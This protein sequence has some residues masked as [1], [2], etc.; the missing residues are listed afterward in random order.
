LTIQNIINNTKKAMQAN[1]P[2]IFTGLGI[3]GVVSTA[4]LTGRASYKAALLI[5]WN[6]GNAGTHA[7]RKQRYKERG[8]L[9]W[10]LYIPPVACGVATI[11]C[12]FG[13]SR[14]TSRRA[15]AAAAA[16]AIAERGFEEYR[17]KV[18]EQLGKGK[19]QKIRDSIAQDKVEKNSGNVIYVGRGL[20][21]CCEL[22]TGRYFRSDMEALKKAEREIN[23]LLLSDLYVMMSEFYDLI[24]LPHTSMSDYM[25]WD[26]GRGLELF[27][28]TTLS[29]DGEPCVAFDYNY[30]KPLA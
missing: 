12:I 10:K 23:Q 15:T 14:V 27:F 13:L 26:S 9:V 19:E 1:S 17:D 11:G 30:A 4:Y 16:Y 28:S 2:Q 21:L 8:K 3:T 24:G 22:H 25:G 18:E 29:E 5:D 6:E 7:D 20:V